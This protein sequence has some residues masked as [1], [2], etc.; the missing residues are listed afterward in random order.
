MAIIIIIIM[1]IVS[2]QTF[3][4]MQELEVEVFHAFNSIMFNLLCIP[5]NQVTRI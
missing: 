1:L 4:S 2:K 5:G 3:L